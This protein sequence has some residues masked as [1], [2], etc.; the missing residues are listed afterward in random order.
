VPLLAAAVE[1]ILF[2]P[3]IAAARGGGVPFYA[4]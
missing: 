2:L 4:G 3:P 1:A